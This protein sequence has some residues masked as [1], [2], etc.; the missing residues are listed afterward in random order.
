MITPID[1]QNKEFTK[2]VRGF[3]EEEVDLFLD[4]VTLDFEKLLGENQN[5]RDE[6]NR[7][8]GELQR[9]VS[10]ENTMIETVASVKLLLQ[11]ITA[12]SEKRAEIIIKNAELEAE[13]ILKEARQDIEK[14]KEE[15]ALLKMRLDTFTTRYKTLLQSELEKFDD[16]NTEFLFED[17]RAMDL[18]EGIKQ[19]E[20]SERQIKDLIHF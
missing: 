8:N 6:I 5:L 16:I 1:I 9:Y 18:E 2:G 11:D 20:D 7:L 15:H 19:E 10:I 13:N 17:K 3:K 12:S 14:M 4:M